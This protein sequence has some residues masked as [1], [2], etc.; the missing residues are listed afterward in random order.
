MS[1][2]FGALMRSSGLAVGGAAPVVVPQADR[3]PA[4][5]VVVEQRVAPAAEPPVTPAAREAVGVAAP[6]PAP[7]APPVPTVP[8]AQQPP[9]ERDT[10]RRESVLPEAPQPAA[11]PTSPAVAAAAPNMSATEIGEVPP[12]QPTAQAVA[13]H[14]LVRAA[15]Q[16]VA[17]GPQQDHARSL[18]VDMPGHE[19]A[20]TMRARGEHAEI[21]ERHTRTSGE[22]GERSPAD[23]HAHANP[24]TDARPPATARPLAR[25]AEREPTPIAP[26]TPRDEP[27]EISIGAIHLR[28]DAPAAQTVART[29]PAPPAAASRAA[30]TPRTER[31]ALARRA[32]RRI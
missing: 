32:L 24:A 15:M 22:P 10:A 6:I 29:P 25:A 17:A 4:M 21:R 8:P 20:A 26:P 9:T 27:V 11:M 14:A 30:S 12:P 23:H 18:A 1:D 2:Y 28:V 3:P 13:A 16:W 5:E 31:S 19:R 7:P